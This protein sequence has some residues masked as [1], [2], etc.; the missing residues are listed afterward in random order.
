M[1]LKSRRFLE[2]ELYLFPLV[3]GNVSTEIDIVIVITTL[4]SKQ[5]AIFILQRS[6]R[7]FDELEK[8]RENY[9]FFNSEKK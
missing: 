3:R 2:N 6:E 4:A 5:L 1:L 9:F 7:I 8:F